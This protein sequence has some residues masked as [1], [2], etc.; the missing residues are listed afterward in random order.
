MPLFT[1]IVADSSVSK[2]TVLFTLQR[3]GH[4][5]TCMVLGETLGSRLA[6]KLQCGRVLAISTHKVKEGGA[7]A[8]QGKHTQR[9]TAEHLFRQPSCGS[10]PGPTKLPSATGSWLFP[11]WYGHMS[12]DSCTHPT[13][14][15]R[16]ILAQFFGVFFFFN[17]MA[18]QSWR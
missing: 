15:A 8:G 16:H 14:K 6:Q 13:E 2:E 1:F 9:W 4:C 7:P 5:S 3:C 11:R 17:L 12:T 18:E 10:S